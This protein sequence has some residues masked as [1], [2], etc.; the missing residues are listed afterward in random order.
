MA[1][2]WSF[3][4]RID[5]H[6]PQRISEAD[7]ARQ[8]ATAQEILHRLESQ[9]GLVLA[10]EVG[11]GKT[12]VA[13]AAATSVAL[14]RSQPVVVMV[15]P[16]LR[17]KWPRDFSL[18]REQCLPR[19]LAQKVVAGKAESAVEFLKLLDDPPKRRK[20]VIF[21]THGAMHG[22]L[23]DGWVKL[24]LLYRTLHHR[25]GAE[26]LR[27]GLSRWMG[28]LLRMRWVE[29]KDPEIWHRL[30]RSPPENWLGIL[31][32]R[33][34][35]PGRDADSTIDNPV[36]REV[37]KAMWE[38]D[39]D[40]LFDV[41]K[42]RVP[43]RSSSRID[44]R[45]K[46]ARRQIDTSLRDLWGRCLRRLSVH[47]PL[48]I[49]DEAHH[50]KNPT[51]RLASLFETPEATADADEISAGP[52][53]G[54]FERMLFLTATPFQLG[55]H[56]L[57]SV[58]DRFDGVRWRGK[59]APT[60]GRERYREQMQTLRHR[61]DRAQAAALK[62]DDAWGRL[63]SEDRVVDGV[64]Y[65]DE[66]QWWK[67]ARSTDDPSDRL[68]TVVQFYHECRN[69]M[70]E[71]EQS[72]RP[73]VIRHRRP[74]YLPAPHAF[75]ARRSRRPGRQIENEAAS[76]ESG[77]TV[78]GDALLPFLLAARATACTPQSRPVFA[79][80]LAS[81][82][83]AFWY[84]REANTASSPTDDD[85]PTDPASAD[86]EAAWYLDHLRRVLPVE[87]PTQS[88]SHP[89]L[90]ATVERVAR[91][92]R[93]GE[94]VLVFCHYVA[95]GQALRRRIAEAIDREIKRV[96]A[97]KLRVSEQEVGRQLDRIGRRF[98]DQD[99]PARQACDA[100]ASEILDGF[101][102]LRSSHREL[103]EIVRRNLRT[104]AFLARFFPL[105]PG[106][107]GR[108][109]IAEAFSTRDG[110][111]MTLHDILVE[112]FRFLAD[113]CGED[114]RR[115]YIDAIKRVQTGAHFGSD[116]SEAYA[117]D[118]LQGDSSDRLVPNVRLVNGTTRPDTRQRL[119]LTFNTPFYPDVLV[120]SS[121]MAEGVDL[122]LNCRHVIHH[123]LG[124]NP[125]TVEQR[126][127]RV[128]R[129]GA[130][131]ERS[132]R[133]LEVCMPY[134]AETQDEKMYRVV[135]DRERWFNVVMGGRFEVD[136]KT[137]EKL[138]E[139]IPLP[140]SIAEELRFDLQY[141]PNEASRPDTPAQCW[142]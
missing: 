114:E 89:K 106:R 50:V 39:T 34:I 64:P 138:A 68:R 129:I 29:R 22:G 110:S 93:T 91:S 75:S 31:Q 53:A 118:E 131:I 80:G 67:A 70:R 120:T 121:V 36:P 124:W 105:G 81:S 72:L 10:D 24:A 125:S 4:E 123:D 140:P 43:E 132:G 104:P 48:L 38:L 30:L 59:N 58:L 17:K 74:R 115:G 137:T 126:T 40:E 35:H 46:D 49:L 96:A 79:E 87:R 127:G 23:N 14:T 102:A 44:E 19:G 97:E 60:M 45:L 92:W 76:D 42:R 62:L 98:F 12:F 52:L 141:A 16:S 112:F 90:A 13:L 84:T 51:T 119:L 63:R 101:P 100:H 111:G 73:W 116:P 94:K 95:T 85:D 55:H 103:R 69:R 8:R 82:F 136:A 7:A 56:E 57:C 15:P 6:V 27:Q 3:C 9:P 113:R 78:Q 134:V 86:E 1:A 122:H 41:L 135:I 77:L 54:V 61:L 83:E 5:L 133:P 142:E 2:S 108:E 37:T 32:E 11:M 139:R 65:R 66:E 21:L 88:P 117:P 20:S 107:F 47:L 25:K 109:A 28:R 99:S 18:F 26:G 33:G 71:A 130:K 128:D